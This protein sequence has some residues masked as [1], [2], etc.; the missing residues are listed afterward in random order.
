MLRRFLQP[1]EAA[2]VF[3]FLTSIK[4]CGTIETPEYER[5]KSDEVNLYFTGIMFLVVFV[6]GGLFICMVLAM[7]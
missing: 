7:R 4:R 5:E 2:S 1:R 3:T 6:L